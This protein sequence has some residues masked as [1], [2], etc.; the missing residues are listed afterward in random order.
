MLP[1]APMKRRLTILSLGLAALTAACSNSENGALVAL[2]DVSPGEDCVAGGT[3]VRA[4]AD[5]NGNGELDDSEVD[6][7]T[8]V[9]NGDEGTKGDDG[10]A[11]ANGP[12]GSKGSK[13][14][15]GKTGPTGPIGDA[16]GD[17]ATGPTGAA[18]PA[19]EPGEDGLSALIRVMAE[20]SGGNCAF[21]G[22]KVEVGLD[23]DGDGNLDER[24]VDANQTR[25]ICDGAPGGAGVAGF[26]LVAKYVAPGGPIA[27]I[28]SPS[29][30]GKTLVYTSSSTGTIGFA[31]ITNP[32]APAL[33]GTTNLASVTGGDGEPT[34]VAFSSDGAHVLAV[35]KDTANP[36]AN[37][38]P[39]A[40]V[41]IN[42]TTRTI[43]G[44]VAIGV[45][46]DSI[47]LTPDGMKAVIAIE[48]EESED[49]NNAPQSRPGSVQVVTINYADPASS[50]I[51][52]VAITPTIGNMPTD[53]QPEYV[54]ITKDGKSAIVSLQENNAFAVIDL[55]TNEVTHYLD[56]GTSV[57]A[58]A[59]LLND[60]K[61]NFTQAYEGQ[62]QPDGTCIL[63]DQ[64]HFI[65]ANE[66]DTSNGA[67][68]GVFAGGRGFSVYNL[69]DG[70][71]ADSG[72]ALEWAALRS[73]AYPDGRSTNRG[74]EPEGCGAGMFGGKPY[75][76]I[77]GERD[78]SLFVIDVADPKSPVIRQVLG[79]PNRPESIAVIESRGL[80]VVGGEGDGAVKG[81]GIWIYEAVN[82][83]SDVGH[84]AHVYEGRSPAG[85]FG[86]LSALAYQ[87]STGLW[88]GLPDNAYAESR[89][90]S[91]AASSSTRRMDLVDELMLRDSAGEVLTDI[92]PEGLVVNPEGG[93]IVATE[94]TG[95][96][97]GGGATCT[98]GKNSNRILFFTALGQLDDSYG[99]VD[100]P[101]GS[102]TNAFDWTIMGSNGFEGVSVVDSL[103]DASGGLKVYVAFQRPLSGS[104]AAAQKTRI[105]EYD[106]DSRTWNFFFYVLEPDLGGA[107]GN[108]FLSELVHVS[109][110]T[111]AVIE[112]DQG[113][114]SS[115]LNKTIRTFSLSTGTVN[116]PN[117][118]VE[119]TTV[120]DL[121]ADSFRFDQEKL[122]GL[123]IGGG[124]LFVVNDNDGG[125]AQ[126]FF[127]RFSP[128]LLGVGG[129][130]T[131]P[132]VI[133]EVVINELASTG[134]PSDFVEL[135]NL[136][137]TPANISGW[138]MTDGGGGVHTFPNGTTLPGGGLLLINGTSTPAL[139]FGLGNGDS[140]ALATSLGTAV[141]S[142][143]YLA[144]VSSSSRCG[145][146][147][148]IFW[149]TNGL[150]GADAGTPGT[151]NACVGPTV[152]GQSDIVVNEVKSNP[153][154]D[155]VE[156][157]NKGAS[158]VD[159]SNWKVLDNDT[160]HTPLV[161]P[162]GTIIPAGGFLLIEGE[163]G[164][165]SLTLPF[166]V[167]NGDSIT[168]FSPYDA[169][170]DAFSWGA[171]HA[172]TANRCPDGDANIVNPLTE[173]KGSANA[174][175]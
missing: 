132:E 125:T 54:D 133:P 61:W 14:S 145:T 66:G 52:T 155:F 20:V 159:V 118:P 110:D 4:G 10:E 48:D 174:C 164:P 37:A 99:I 141:D 9:C 115:A 148:L 32:S 23:V 65:T 68:G 135:K 100:L 34:S 38:D 88:L 166:G 114:A 173:T 144:H 77:T 157:Y 57:H 154:T 64:K 127:V 101:C 150:N 75:A 26:R 81:G 126:N 27:E 104:E 94:G 19:G 62:A 51:E 136:G 90:W 17:A 165:G 124:S 175:P 25:Y 8:Y 59:D 111:F 86:A 116:D 112:R 46:P 119:K 45:G 139:A 117:D 6:D 78:S 47:A 13:G 162:S 121:L 153:G 76:F 24:E 161:L 72:D 74:M 123:A 3:R 36:I 107:S 87:K 85:S 156:L 39:G 137:S 22:T 142:Y 11:G 92:D 15:D 130:G 105:G 43:V 53:P 131:A 58:H 143:V 50:T 73:G 63:P 167:G 79:A 108:T 96:N 97:G 163:G 44:Q 55:E 21:G 89:I 102:D 2:A 33:L 169:T 168:L 28:V 30:D 129:G 35:V 147:G 71:V 113:Y 16:G 106:V 80:I 67:F 41:V 160:S 138:T 7:T 151:E 82:E 158:D 49:G 171:V 83:P 170:V 120:I 152:V 40:L 91:F 128:N 29:P 122:E 109:G 12:K 31:D 93:F 149:P 5:D 69:E 172:T 140:V 103:P 56:A 134:F 95:S 18:G 1:T 98:G 146:S 84:G 42:A 70:R 60:R